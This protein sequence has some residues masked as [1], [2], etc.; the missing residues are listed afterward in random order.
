M[1][2]PC[3]S[4]VPEVASWVC[5]RDAGPNAELVMEG[6]A[7]ASPMWLFVSKPNKIM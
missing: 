5:D 1:L 7:H 2:C 4:L 3:I 6:T